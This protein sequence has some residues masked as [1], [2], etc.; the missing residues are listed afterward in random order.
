M[1]SY[2]GRSCKTCNQVQVASFGPGEKEANCSFEI[3]NNNIAEGILVKKYY[4][5]LKHPER[6]I[7]TSRNV[8]D[9]YISDL[10]DCK[11]IG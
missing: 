1:G 3:E 7:T 9:V 4:V 2:S 5:S 8:T 10:E 11:L 6:A